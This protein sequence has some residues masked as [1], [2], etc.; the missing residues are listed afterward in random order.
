MDDSRPL[1]NESK[2]IEADASSR[3]A[4]IATDAA[5]PA[6]FLQLGLSSV[7]SDVCE[8][9]LSWSSPTPIQREVIPLAIQGHDIIALAQTGSGKTGA[10]LLPILQQLL[11][12]PSN[13]QALIC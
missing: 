13:A 11:Q 10:F 1:T 12:R 9:Q 5:T 6:T 3:E 4:S 8:N 2:V 7:L